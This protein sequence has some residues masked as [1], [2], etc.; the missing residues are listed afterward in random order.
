MES[1]FIVDEIIVVEDNELCVD[2]GGA[3][4]LFTEVTATA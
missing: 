3:K 1:D 4:V 2:E